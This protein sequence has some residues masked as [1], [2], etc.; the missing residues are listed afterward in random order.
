VTEHMNLQPDVEE[1]LQAEPEPLMTIPVCVN[2]VRSPVRTQ[3]LP[4]K[5]GSTQTKSVSTT[6]IRVLTADPFRAE[7]TFIA[8]GDDMQIAFTQTAAQADSS[9]AFWPQNVPFHCTANVEIWVSANA[10][11]ATISIITERWAEVF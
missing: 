6:P 2:E 3:A 9:M 4:R 1:V 11:N 7:A 8:H 5:G 10:S